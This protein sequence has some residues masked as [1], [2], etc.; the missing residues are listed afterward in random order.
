MASSYELSQALGLDLNENKLLKQALTHKSKGSPHNERLEFLGDAILSF[1]I[2][3]ELYQRFP[4]V[5][6]GVLSRLRSNLVKGETLA[7]L[8]QTLNLGEHLRLGAGEM[9]SGG[10]HRQSILA[11]A[12]EAVLGAI[13]LESGL[14][15][16]RSK[17]LIWYGDALN[18]V[19]VEQAEKDPKTLLQEW[20]QSNGEALPVYRIV[21]IE[22]EPHAQF[23]TVNCEAGLGIVTEGKGNSRRQAEQFAAQ[24]ALEQLYALK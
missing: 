20:L 11:D 9:K 7:K 6:E 3:T 8:A 14:E 15:R 10:H 1:V 18:N 2:T 5:E 23:F 13:Y 22:G 24:K 12:F 4:K 16:V 17:I 21:T 19:A